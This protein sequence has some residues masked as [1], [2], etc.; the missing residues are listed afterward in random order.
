MIYSENREGCCESPEGTLSHA[1][2]QVRASKAKDQ[3]VG[4]LPTTPHPRA[5]SCTQVPAAQHSSPPQVRYSS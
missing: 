5:A 3:D 2:G 1:E 4:P